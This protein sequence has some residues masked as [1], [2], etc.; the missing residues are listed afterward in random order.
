MLFGLQEKE[1]LFRRLIAKEA[2][3][4]AYLFFGESQV[5]KFSLALSLAGFLETGDFSAATR[6]LIDRLII[7]PDEKGTMGVEAVRR[8]RNFLWQT[9]L[10]SSRRTVILK[11]MEALTPEAQG[12]LLKIVEEPPRHALLI[13]VTTA[14]E[15]LL[16]PLRSRFQKIYFGRLPT[17]AVR[18]YLV[19]E[20]KMPATKAL[21]LA[22]QALGRIGL[23]NDLF[24]RKTSDAT[25]EDLGAE[26]NRRIVKL[27]LKDKTKHAP[28]LFR[29]LARET[30]W[31]R[32]NLNGNLQKKAIEYLESSS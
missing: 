23:A 7:E 26:L 13:G 18:D 11:R 9:P 15:T 6:P 22:E 32:F 28:I 2:L 21:I 27:W 1:S 17:A 8:I 20:K 14:T 19:K 31:H 29:L 12:A 25:S 5:G 24:Q 16:P 30:A 3:A 4:Q 10:A